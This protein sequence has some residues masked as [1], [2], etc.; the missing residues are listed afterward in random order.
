MNARVLCPGPSLACYA[1]EDFAGLLIGINRA[2]IA[3]RTDV[4]ACGDYPAV[5]EFGPAVLGSPLLLTAASTDAAT[6]CRGFTWPGQIFEFERLQSF[7]ASSDALDWP[8][9]TF[10][11]AIVYAAFRGAKRID[12]YG[13]DWEGA[14]DFDG[15]L[16]G[17]NRSPA[18][19]QAERG[20]FARL[21]IEM[22]RRGITLER[23]Q[24]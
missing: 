14:E 21:K 6:R 19:W 3:H 11:I 8:F 12:V 23:V 15:K 1:P 9:L 18:R 13:A 22:D 2:S 24:I 16:A 20:L 5:A 17:L 7:I 4:W 10:S